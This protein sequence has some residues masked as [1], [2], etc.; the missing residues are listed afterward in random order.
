MDDLIRE[1]QSLKDTLGWSEDCGKEAPTVTRAVMELC[2]LLIALANVVKEESTRTAH[3]VRRL[4]KDT[5]Y[6]LG[7]RLP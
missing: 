4:E 5:D 1:I 2:D 7:P 3:A 6:L